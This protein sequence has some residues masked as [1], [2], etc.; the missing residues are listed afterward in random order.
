MTESQRLLRTFFICSASLIVILTLAQEVEAR[1][2]GRGRTGGRGGS[3]SRGGSAQWGSMRGGGTSNRGGSYRGGS[4]ERGS[5][6]G[7]YDYSRSQ[8]N[9]PSRQSRGNDWRQQSGSTQER[10]RKSQSGTGSYSR[11]TRA[12]GSVDASKTVD[13]DTTNRDATLKG[14]GGGSIDYSGSTTRTDE[15]F[16]RSGSF[17][18]SGGAS[19]SGETNVE[20]GNHG[21]ENVERKRSVETA[22]GE[23]IDREISSKRDGDWRVREGT[24]ETSTGVD[25]KTA[26]VFKKTDD[27]F[28]AR[29]A[30]EGD[31]YAGA[32]A[33]VRDGNNSYRR[34]AITNGNSTVY[35]RSH[36]NGGS[37]YGVRGTAN[38]NSYY[39]YP[40]Y[41]YPYYYAYYACPPNSSTVVVGYYGT[42]VY[43]CANVFVVSTTVTVSSFSS[44]SPG[45]SR[46]V[47][48]QATSAPVVMYD[49]EAGVVVYSTSYE[50]VNVYSMKH[51][52][53]HYWV[54]GIHKQSEQ[55]DEWIALAL[56]SG[57]P[58]ANATV[59]TYKI[60]DHLVY[61]TNEPPAKGIHSQTADKL[62][63]WIAGTRE[64]T[65]EERDAI[66]TALTAH[67]SGGS[68][69]LEREVRKLQESR[70]PPAS[71][72]DES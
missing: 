46:P 58:S 5:R 70:E 40:Y 68:A 48:V 49:L 42:P 66:A 31:N 61:L 25:A 34:G 11:E 13:G 50:P 35:G 72:T 8:T 10:N 65:D 37:C 16:S 52:G 56:K 41:Y 55:A 36:C 3:V 7:S 19:G 38:I 1:G 30:F 43:S 71:L 51:D 26:S 29:G 21:V 27:G 32:G 39:Y 62:H 17:E 69:S 6:A 14:S 59:I 22:S 24:I 45:T 63:A 20:I 64:P 33:V 60:G 2:G 18:T 67:R 9:S 53:R 28:I 47:E 54:P 23:T 57:K 15:G 12:G 4:Y 44:A